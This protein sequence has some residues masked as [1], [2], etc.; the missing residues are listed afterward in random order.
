MGKNSAQRS[1][2]L[3]TCIITWAGLVLQYYVAIESG[4]PNSLSFIE[5]TTRFFGYFTV[6]TNLLV[7][8]WLTAILYSRGS[9]HRFFSRFTAQTAVT[10]YILVVGLGYNILLRHLYVFKGLHAITTEIQHVA[11]P[12]LATVYWVL[13]VRKQ[14]LP[15][16]AFLP[17]LL[18]PFI[19]LV[20]AL[21]RGSLDGFYPYPF[22]NVA[23]LGLTTVFRNAAGLLVVF[24]VVSLI[25]IAVSR[26]KKS[27]AVN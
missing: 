20:I 13:Y 3:V 14:S 7:A 6:L 8:V 27:L 23:E 17:W 2:A 11:V 5:S 9:L 22:L 10:V 15:W 12:A 16:S 25:F 24:V 19:Y 4:P 21:F 26:R 1:F 18:Y